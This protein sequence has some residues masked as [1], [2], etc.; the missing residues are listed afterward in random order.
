MILFEEPVAANVS[1]RYLIAAEF[2]WRRLMS[3]A[4]EFHGVC[5]ERKKRKPLAPLVKF[6]VVPAATFVVRAV[7]VSKFVEP[8]MMLVVPIVRFVMVK[9]KEPFGKTAGKISSARG[10]GDGAAFT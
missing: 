4:T 10:D 2:Y 6:N 5:R 8:S 7:H 1:L 3:A 9:R